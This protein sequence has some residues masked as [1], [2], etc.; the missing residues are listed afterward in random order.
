V[1]TDAGL[2]EIEDVDIGDRVSQHNGQAC[3]AQPFQRDEQSCAVVTVEFENP[4]GYP[5]EM[6]VELMRS[7]SWLDKRDVRL[8][9]EVE[10]TI[11]EIGVDGPG[12]VSAIRSC[13][14]IEEGK[15]CLVT[16]T[17]QHRNRDVM[18]LEFVDSELVLQPTT[19]HPLWS[20][21]R[22]GWVRAGALEVGERLLTQ[23][24][25]LQIAEIRRLEGGHQV[26]NL[27]V[28]GDHYY[29]VGEPGV[30]AHNNCVE[31]PTKESQLEHIFRDAPGHANPTTKN[32]RRAWSNLFKSV[33]SKEG[34]LVENPVSKGII[35]KQAKNAGVKAYSKSYSNGKQV[36]VT[37]RDGT[38]QNAGV[39]RP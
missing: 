20:A 2:E 19:L 31:M 8:G 32:G 16:G 36:W 25:T 37:V 3:S 22:N 21:D 34:N 17:F 11:E 12:L 13:P 24:G 10:W 5:D 23:Q 29:L 28:A 39:N 1:N 18:E 38:I 27:E 30:V 4:Y 15:A 9:Q 35:T 26:Y 33:A 14:P 7:R 6:V